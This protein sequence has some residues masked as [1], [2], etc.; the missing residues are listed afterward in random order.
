M[1]QRHQRATA[2]IALDDCVTNPTFGCV[3]SSR[4]SQRQ[5]SL[6]GSLGIRVVDKLG[7]LADRKNRA[8]AYG[9][10]PQFCFPIS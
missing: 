9:R 10:A 5:P 4:Y 8:L 3:I 2:M 1:P 6:G 7:D